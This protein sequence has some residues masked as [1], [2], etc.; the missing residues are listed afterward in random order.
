[1]DVV[2]DVGGVKSVTSVASVVFVVWV[3]KVEL[4]ASV[5]VKVAVMTWRR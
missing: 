2:G 4:A 5:V 1:M 3:T